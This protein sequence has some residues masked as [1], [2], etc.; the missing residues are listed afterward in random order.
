MSCLSATDFAAQLG[1]EISDLH[2]NKSIDM[3]NE[4]KKDNCQPNYWKVNCAVFN[5][6]VY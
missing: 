2:S 1:F 6:V 5:L 3:Y 4:W